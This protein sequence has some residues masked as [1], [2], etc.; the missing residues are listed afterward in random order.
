MKHFLRS[1]F[2]APVITAAMISTALPAFAE[3]VVRYTPSAEP[4][5][6][7]PVANWLLITHQHGYMVYDTLFSLDETMTPQPQMV[8][9]YSV[10]ADGKTHTMSLRPGLKFHDGSPVTSKDVIASIKRWASRDTIGQRLIEMG[11][12]LEPVD[13][14][15]FA[16]TTDVPTELV[17]QG[18]AKPTAAAL[19]IMREKEAMT[20]ATTPVAEII[21]SGPF[22]FVKDEYKPGAKIVYVKNE[23]YVPRDE[24]PSLLAGGKVVNVDK[25]EW[26]IMPDATTAVSALQ[27]GETDIYEAPPM[28]LLP[29]LQSQ[30]NIVTRPLGPLG[31]M[32]FVRFNFTQPPFDNV[33]ARK[34]VAL[35]VDQ[36]SIMSVVAGTDGTYWDECYSFF[37]CGGGNTTEAGMDWTR[38]RN[39]AEAKRLIENSGYDGSP[40]VLIAPSDN[41]VL[42]GVT[43]VLEAE[44]K[45]GGF[46]V[47]VQWSDFASMMA[48]RQIRGTPA[49]GGWNMF[50]MW[51][52]TFELD[53][54]IGNFY[55]NAACDQGYV[56]WFCN[57]AIVEARSNWA[58]AATL[59]EAKAIVE[60]IQEMSADSLPIVPLGKFSSP[61]AFSDDISGFLDAPLPVF[62]NLEK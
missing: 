48:R 18:F 29:L 40:I 47:D 60:N 49:E 46:N 16:V 55:M 27:L 1:T 42:K 30:G 59:E 7:D 36:S 23:N 9:D 11:M 33:E 3:T 28:D 20:E 15:T 58:K 6:L 35:L 31:Q 44:L 41:E 50:P 61:I 13:E 53:N 2:L 4:K 34:A 14:T 17:L 22:K 56:G 8:G 43:T 21:G 57:P 62:W 25:V 24:P 54:P 12:A 52:F 26:L 45:E 5:T 10:S 51:S 19:F 37:A 38:E 32:A 39:V